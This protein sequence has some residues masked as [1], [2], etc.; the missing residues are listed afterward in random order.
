MSPKE[1]LADEK[2]PSGLIDLGVS[3]WLLFLSDYYNVWTIVGGQWNAWMDALM[4]E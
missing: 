1:L 3:V 4:D 2:T